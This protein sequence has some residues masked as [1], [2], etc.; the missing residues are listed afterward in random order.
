MVLPFDGK[1]LDGTRSHLTE[2][3]GE[4]KRDTHLPGFTRD[5]ARNCLAIL[6]F[7]L[8]A[9]L[10][11][12]VPATRYPNFVALELHADSRLL[13]SLCSCYSKHTGKAGRICKQ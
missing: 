13:D 2:R 1:G 7:R 5:E 4:K 6:P 11:Q 3:Q 8:Y 9:V 10:R 12:W